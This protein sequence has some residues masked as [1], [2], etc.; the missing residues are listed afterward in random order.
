[1]DT[2]NKNNQKVKDLEHSSYINIDK[3]KIKLENIPNLYEKKDECYGCYACYN[4]CMSEGG[5]A[6]LMLADSQ[7]FYYPIIDVSKCIGCKKCLKVCQ[8]VLSNK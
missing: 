7:G 6:I 4:I 1:M 3:S 8:F 2:Y 5:N